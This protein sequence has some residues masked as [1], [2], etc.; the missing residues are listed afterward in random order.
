MSNEAKVPE[1]V[2]NQSHR[3]IGQTADGAH[4]GLAHPDAPPPLTSKYF[5]SSECRH[6]VTL[7]ERL[8]AEHF[9]ARLELDAEDHAQGEDEIQNIESAWNTDG[10]MMTDP[11]LLIPRRCS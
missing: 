10:A 7:I 9:R 11:D 3:L 1:P 6:M 5:S 4:A 8:R 2:D